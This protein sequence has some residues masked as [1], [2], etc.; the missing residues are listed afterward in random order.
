MKIE[1]PYGVNKPIAITCSLLL[2]KIHVPELY[3]IRFIGL[4]A[5]TQ[6]EAVLV[7]IIINYFFPEIKMHFIIKNKGERFR[8]ESVFWQWNINQEIIPD[9]VIELETITQLVII[10]DSAAVSFF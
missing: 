6:E 5:E 7:E 10:G 4:I 2:K 8:V 3:I 9:P 1:H